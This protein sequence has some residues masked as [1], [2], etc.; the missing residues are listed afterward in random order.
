[1]KRHFLIEMQSFSIYSCQVW[2]GW[3]ETNAG[4]AAEIP[5]PMVLEK[6][7]RRR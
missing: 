1:L 6:P 5:L 3:D 7:R 4:V 2:T